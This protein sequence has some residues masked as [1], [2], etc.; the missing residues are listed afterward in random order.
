MS[1][2]LNHEYSPEDLARMPDN[3]LLRSVL[4]RAYTQ[5]FTLIPHYYNEFIE[6]IPALE[7]TSCK[8]MDP[9]VDIPD[10][11][12]VYA[13]SVE[14]SNGILPNNSY[15]MYVGKGGELGNNSSISK[16]YRSYF[17]YEN[18]P[19][20]RPKLHTL[21]SLWK[22]HITYSFARTPAGVSPGE[23]EKKLNNILQPPF[24]YMDFTAEVRYDRRGANI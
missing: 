20:D 1:I 7:W 22:D 23:V 6:D 10:E 4:M 24:S 14:F 3:P 16:R 17:K 15:V 5:D 9:N 11:Q 8:F 18:A 2:Q 13:F 19:H 21:F 12:G